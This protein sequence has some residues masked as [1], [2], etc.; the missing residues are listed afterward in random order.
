MITLIAVLALQEDRHREVVYADRTV[1]ILVPVAGETKHVSTVVTFP[2]ESIEALVAGWNEEDLSLERR[3]ER[4]FVKLLRR[5][6]GDLHVLGAS[7]TLYR[8][9]VRAGEKVYDG[10]V[11][12]VR[13]GKEPSKPTSVDLIRAMRTGRV[14]EGATVRRAAGVVR[15]DA[16]AEWTAR[17]VYDTDFHR[18][19]VIEVRNLSDGPLRLDLS[20]FR[21][22]GLD[23]AGAGRLVVEPGASTRIYL[24]YWK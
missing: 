4:L 24:V 21:G 17:F 13:P 5:A 19:Y 20:R 12:I 8:L 14:P 10:Q 11:R 16:R 1:E 22:E 2:E 3:R 23:L 18:G 6:E 9:Y 7:G 15:R